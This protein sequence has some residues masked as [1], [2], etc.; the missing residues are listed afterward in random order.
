LLSLKTKDVEDVEEQGTRPG[1]DL[2]IY[3]SLIIQRYVL[4]TTVE[5]CK[6]RRWN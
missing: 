2:V 1:V 5:V 4:L 6:V 3:Y